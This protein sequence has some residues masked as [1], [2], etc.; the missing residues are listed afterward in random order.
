M[1]VYLNILKRLLKNK[2]NLLLMLVLP[3]LTLLPVLTQTSPANYKLGV[4]DSDKTVLT[5]NLKSALKDDFTLVPMNKD[6]IKNFI[7]KGKVNYIIVIDKGYT[8]SILLGEESTING[9]GNK[10]YEIYNLVEASINSYINPVKNIAAASKRDKSKFYS[11]LKSYNKGNI[12]F[13]YNKIKKIDISTQKAAWGLIVMFLMMTSVFS[14]T[15]IIKDSINKTL[16]RSLSAPIKLKSYMVQNILCFLT[17]S[18]LQVLLLCFTSVYVFK[19]KAGVSIINI[20]ILLV[21]FTLVG[22]SLGV[23]LSSFIKQELQ[24]SILGWCITFLM[25]MVGGSWGEI[26]S[27]WIKNIGKFTPVSYVMDG[28]DKLMSNGSL[29]SVRNDI[30]VLMLFS[31]IFFMLGTW[32]KSDLSQ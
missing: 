22:I 19:V 11:S 1:I 29:W 14:S 18:I 2:L 25:C 17:I 5:E 28:V 15:I 31:L 30:L 24:C 10:K 4:V 23:L 21:V 20:I 16:Y 26:G 6:Q 27:D 32:K 3:L 13:T 12:K 7:G 9:Y 8:D